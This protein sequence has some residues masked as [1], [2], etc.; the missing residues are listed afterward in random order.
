MFKGVKDGDGQ[1]ES[2]E[3]VWILREDKNQPEEDPVPVTGIV[4]ARPQIACRAIQL[5]NYPIQ[6]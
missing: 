5:Q 2:Q 4:I 1:S 3:D 6:R